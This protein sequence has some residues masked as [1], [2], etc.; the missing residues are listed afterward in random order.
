MKKQQGFTLIE[1]M[2]V[3]AI[4]GILAAVALP[5]YQDYTIRT[6]VSEGLNLAKEVQAAANEFRV[7]RGRFPSTHASAGLPQATSIIGN[8]VSTLT[9]DSNG[10][11]S[12]MYGNKANAAITGQILAIAP[13]TPSGTVTSSSPLTWICGNSAVS[14][15]SIIGGSNPGTT[16]TLQD[17]HMPSACRP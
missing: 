1:L 13:A 12:I 4:I 9:L 15:V 3:V 7:D 2:I 16:T 8:Y 14:R 17:K 10:M 5:A 6:Q 11:I